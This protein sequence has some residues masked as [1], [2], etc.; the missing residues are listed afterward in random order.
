MRIYIAGPM[1]GYPE[2]N[3]PAFHRAAAAWRTAGWNVCNPAEHFGGDQSKRYTEYVEAD[4]AA[5]KGCDA[6]AMLPG[7]DA[8]T[9]GAIWEHYVAR[10]VLGLHVFDAT[11]PRP[12]SSGRFAGQTLENLNAFFD[13][14]P[15]VPIPLTRGE[16]KRL[17]RWLPP[18]PRHGDEGFCPEC[19]RHLRGSVWG[20]EC[21]RCE[22][23]E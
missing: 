15:G 7:W 14:L 11:N 13:A 9:S 22:P 12:A 4:V 10:D 16:F 21:S 8:G 3:Y 18:R 2:S 23:Q 19:G 17:G 5:L 20:G 6:I 1:T